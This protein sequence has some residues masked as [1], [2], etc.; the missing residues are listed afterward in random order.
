MRLRSDS[1]TKEQ[2]VEAT[3]AYIRHTTELEK[4]D[5]EDANFLECF[6]GTNLRRTEIVS[7]SEFS[8]MLR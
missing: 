1:P 7:L 4:A 3:L 5:M 6:K 2:E 8:L